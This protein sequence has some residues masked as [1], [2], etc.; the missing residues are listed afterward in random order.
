MKVAKKSPRSGSARK[1]A[2]HRVRNTI[3]QMIANGRFRPGEKLVQLQLSR[4]FGCSL[5]MVREALFELEGLGLVES[6]DNRGVQVRSLDAQAIHELQVLREV[7]DGVAARECCGK[8]KERDA[9]DLRE[10]AQRIY[11]LSVAGEFE[12]KNLLDRQFHLRIAELSNNRL[13]SDLSRQHQVLGKVWGQTIN[14]ERTLREHVAIIDA[15]LKADPDKA[16]ALA[17]EHLRHAARE[18]PVQ[19]AKS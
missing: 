9:Q 13:L 18:T 11:D 10:L 1:I 2:R 16:E 4:Q 15:I 17:R 6:F 3:E 14:A 8:M 7:F 12:E 5:G 19:T